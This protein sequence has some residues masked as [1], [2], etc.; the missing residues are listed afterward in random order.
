[1]E[2]IYEGLTGPQREA[3]AH[4]DGPLM[5]LAGPGSG[6]T[7]VVTRRIANLLAKGVPPWQI[8]ALTFTNKA[9]DEMRKR[10]SELAPSQPVWMGTFHRFCSQLLRRYHDMVGLKGN[11]SIL[12]ANDSKVALKRAI[13]AAGIEL[14]HLKEDRLANIISRAKNRMITPD[15]MASGRG[16]QYD[17][18]PAVEAY[19]VYQAHLLRA[20]S[21]DFDDLL[22]HVAQM[23]HEYPE[24]RSQLDERYRYILVDE[25]QDTNLVQYAIVRALSIDHP[26]LA[27]TGDPDQSIYGWRG[28]DL[29]NILNFEEHYPQV[30]VIRLEQN[31][32]STPEILRVADQ[33]IRNN[34]RRKHKELF[35]QN[36]SGAS[37]RLRTYEDASREAA[38]IADQ[39][40]QGIA[41]RNRRAREH[42]IFCRTA[43]LTRTFEHALRSRG[44]PYHVSGAVEFYQRKE[45]KDLLAYLLLVHNPANDVAFLRVINSPPRGIGKKTVDLLQLHADRQ[46][47]P[48]LDAARKSGILDEVPKRSAV[49]IAEFVA[50]LDRFREDSNRSLRALLQEIVDDTGYQ[51]MLELA[52]E[53]ADDGNDRQANVDELL[54]AAAEIDLVYPPGEGLE[55]FLEQVALISDT[56]DLDREADYVN[57]MTIHAAKGLEFPCVFVIAV[58]DGLIPHS[59]SRDNPDQLEEERRLLF[60]AMTRAEQELQLSWAQYRAYRGDVRGSVPSSFLMELPREEMD[61]QQPGKFSFERIASHDFD[62]IDQ[63]FDYTEEWHSHG[64]RHVPPFPQQ[65]PAASLGSRSTTKR[66]PQPR[67]T[68]AT[69][70]LTTAARLLEAQSHVRRIPPQA[71]REGLLVY[72]PAH[73]RGRVVRLSGIGPRRTAVIEFFLDRVERSFRVAFADLT[74]DSDEGPGEPTT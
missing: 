8:A 66:Q 19:R 46:R 39:I 34:R 10:V 49:R 64:P 47:I 63:S 73:G 57:V 55:A 58:E 69:T 27:V 50:M 2:A 56:D 33:L 37:V 32:R 1:M 25:Y 44:I 52:A 14:S 15:L 74:I 22:L 54:S 26:N 35:T 51:K 30:R 40:A 71:Y 11:F 38:E 67:S 5:I 62:D 28:A 60:V 9:A 59:R 17:E 18:L 13:E 23:L 21:V 3:V 36:A 31:Y 48:L 72:H 70:P 20:N 43:A 65:N 7:R 4:Q 24:L 68:P 12:D 61:L 16:I 53:K 29:N 41:S 6:K 45:I 42:A